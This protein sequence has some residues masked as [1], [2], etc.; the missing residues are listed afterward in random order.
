MPTLF[1]SL[2]GLL[3]VFPFLLLILSLKFL[4][5]AL[6][7]SLCITPTA[8]VL[9]VPVMH[10]KSRSP[11]IFGA[12]LCAEVLLVR[13]RAALNTKFETLLRA[14]E[15]TRACVCVCVFSFVNTK[16]GTEVETSVLSTWDMLATRLLWMYVEIKIIVMQMR[17]R[18][19]ER[20]S[21]ADKGATRAARL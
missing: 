11:I 6:A 5:L 16:P 1:L 13:L 18:F 7:L 20:G 12:A 14:S 9:L 10:L 15:S 8:T 21:R 4:P 3:A 2:V 17:C 19:V